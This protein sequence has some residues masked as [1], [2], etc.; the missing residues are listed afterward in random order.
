MSSS[1]APSRY[2]GHD[3]C[4]NAYSKNYGCND[5][6]WFKWNGELYGFPDIHPQ[7]FKKYLDAP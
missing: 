1:G 4:L 6:V 7:D 2:G 5:C 3:H